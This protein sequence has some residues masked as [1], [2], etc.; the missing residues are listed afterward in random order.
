MS[1]MLRTLETSLATLTL[2]EPRFIEQRYKPTARFD[3]KG[4]EENQR[5]REE[6]CGGVLCAVMVVI[7]AEMPVHPP[8]VNMDHFRA[9]RVK[10]N[11][12]ALAVV[13]DSAIMHTTTKLYFMYFQQAFHVKVFEEERDARRWLREHLAAEPA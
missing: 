6:L 1:A 2:V 10:R 8:S 9:E 4:L 5:A 13:T 11:I 7:P 3:L 12:L